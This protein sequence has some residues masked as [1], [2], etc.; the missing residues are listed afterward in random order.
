MAS[1]TRACRPSGGR[2]KSSDVTGGSRVWIAAAC[3]F[4]FGCGSATNG[5]NAGAAVEQE[6]AKKPRVMWLAA[7]GDDESMAGGFLARACVKDRLACHFFVF[8]RDA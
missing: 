5:P 4:A 6:L 8:N 1:S 2:G 7:H 3:A